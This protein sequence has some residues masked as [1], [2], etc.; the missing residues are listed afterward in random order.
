RADF[1]VVT[2]AS[3]PDTYHL[4]GAEEFAACKPNAYI[5]NVARGTAIDPDALDDALRSGKIA[6]AGIDVTEP[7]PLPNGHPLWTAPNLL[8]SPHVGGG[9]SPRSAD[10]LSGRVVENLQR[11]IDGTLKPT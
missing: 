2:I 10:R 1:I 6:G 7:E 8:I 5:V 3:S 4:I 9:G 11:F